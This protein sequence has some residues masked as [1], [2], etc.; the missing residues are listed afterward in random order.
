[1]VRD[2][3]SNRPRL[4]DRATDRRAHDLERPPSFCRSHGKNYGRCDSSLVRRYFGGGECEGGQAPFLSNLFYVGGPAGGGHTTETEY[5][6]S[7]R[8]SR[9]DPDRGCPDRRD[10]DLQSP[11]PP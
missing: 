6:D 10:G 2:P 5:A 3:E 4:P 1:M 11:L 9:A 7:C 8:W